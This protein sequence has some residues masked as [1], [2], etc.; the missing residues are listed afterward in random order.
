MRRRFGRRSISL[1][2]LIVV[3]VTIVHAAEPPAK[4]SPRLTHAEEVRLIEKY[5]KELEAIYHK[6]EFTEKDSQ[7]AD[8]LETE[9]GRLQNSVSPE[10]F[11]AWR[12]QYVF[13]SLTERLAYERRATIEAK[14]RLST[15]ADKALKELDDDWRHH[16]GGEVRAESLQMLHTMELDE[17]VSKSGFG[18]SR[19]PKVGVQTVEAY[20]S[21]PVAPD[22]AT[23]LSAEELNLVARP[24][25]PGDKTSEEMPLMPTLKDVAWVHNQHHYTFATP[26]NFGWVKSLSQVAGFE[27]HAFSNLP[28]TPA[29]LAYPPEK[30]KITLRED[31]VEP[32]RWKLTRLELVSLLKYE[33]PRVYLSEHL[34][35]MDE[36]SSAKT[37]APA[38]FES[39]ALAVLRDGEDLQTA[40]TPNRIEMLGAI[41]ASKQCLQCHDVPRGTLLGAFSYEL[42]RDPPVPVGARNEVVQ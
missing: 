39:R 21:K 17:F 12:K 11:A 34:P 2:L 9:V 31:R 18:I 15:A 3:G 7:R 28:A 35:R 22:T 4:P 13:Q 20:V 36:L 40:A 8:E 27:P 19:M 29:V 25:P 37:R 5:E 42:R 32:K 16:V 10:K 38:E 30:L 23:P 41:R 1:L 26:F 14:P 24:L 6:E 33:M